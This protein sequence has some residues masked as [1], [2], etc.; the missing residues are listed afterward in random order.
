MSNISLSPILNQFSKHDPVKKRFETGE[1]KVRSVLV[2]LNGIPVISLTN[3]LVYKYDVMLDIWV[4]LFD[5]WYFQNVDQ[6]ALEQ[7][8]SK[9]DNRIYK[10]M[11]DRL[12]K[13]V[14]NGGRSPDEEKEV[15]SDEVKE[16][17]KDT[18]NQL[19]DCT[20]E[21]SKHL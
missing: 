14:S 21:Q 3:D 15:V 17:I 12:I 13:K 5:T 19:I 9:F 16:S 10:I 6:T 20:I 4:N 1:V 2:D 7:L 11:V 18:F 8:I